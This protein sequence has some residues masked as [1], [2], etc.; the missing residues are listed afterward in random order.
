M[1]YISIAIDGPAGAGKSTIARMVAQELKMLYVDTGAMY[2]AFALYCIQHNIEPVEH[3]IDTILE[4][5]HIEI[6]YREGVQ[7]VLLNNC[8]VN[9]LIRSEEVGK[10]ASLISSHKGVRMKLIQIQQEFAGQTNVVMDG[11]DIGTFVLPNATLKIYLTASV[12][13]RANR[14][15]SQLNKKGINKDLKVLE[16]DIRE[17][18]DKDMNRSFAPLKKAKDAVVLDSSDLSLKQVVAQIIELVKRT[19]TGSD[20]E[21]KL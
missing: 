18:D 12:S 7:Q 8:N 10:M 20:L 11:R 15:W 6:Q 19:G 16:K 3:K 14:R 4:D 13:V 5:V 17:R 9:A 2:R 1:T 21:C